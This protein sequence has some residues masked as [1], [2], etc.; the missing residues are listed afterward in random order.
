M[1]D[2]IIAAAMY[3]AVSTRLKCPQRRNEFLVWLPLKCSDMTIGGA[4]LNEVYLHSGQRFTDVA[5]PSWVRYS[6][7]QGHNINRRGET[8]STRL[9]GVVF[10]KIYKEK[11]KDRTPIM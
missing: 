8:F 7:A 11:E 5:L 6:I 4:L 1:R 9:G 3:A 2:V 10:L